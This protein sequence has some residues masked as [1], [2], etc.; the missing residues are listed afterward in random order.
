MKKGIDERIAARFEN[1]GCNEN[2]Y[3][4]KSYKM[5][6]ARLTGGN[7]KLGNM[8]TFNKLYGNDEFMTEYGKIAGSCGDHCRGC[9]AA[10]YVR[11]S[12]RYPSVIKGHARNTAAMRLD[13]K[14]AF[15]DIDAQLSRKRTPYNVVRIHQSGE[16]E[17]TDELINWVKIA[18]RHPE[19][20]FYIYTKNFQA[21]RGLIESGETITSNF[22]L[23][24]SIWH[25]IGI[26]EYNQYKNHDFI[27]AFVYDD[28]N[29][30]YAAAGLN[31]QAYCPAYDEN[32]KM[33]H[34]KTCEKCGLCIHSNAKI[35][36]CHDH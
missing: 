9:K 10:C 25:E 6:V 20:R 32:G 3:I 7:I 5:P 34:E 19:T 17:S 30:N 14:K 28:H 21:L 2:D 16:I 11:K 18:A 31:I 26:D 22:T 29:F 4:V 35:I 33:N 8:A 23:L 12:Y 36:G 13:M 24:I 27:K 15:S 1:A